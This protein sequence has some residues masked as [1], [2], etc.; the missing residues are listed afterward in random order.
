MI[1]K[2]LIRYVYELMGLEIVLSK[3]TDINSLPLYMIKKY[4]LFNAR[5]FDEDFIVMFVKND[6]EITL[7][8]IK[9]HIKQLYKVIPI[10]KRVVLVCSKISNYG[11]HSLIKEK[12]PFIV[13]GLQLYVPFLG[14]AYKERIEEKY[15]YM[16][17]E[18]EK[19]ETD[20][21]PKRLSPTTQAL[22]FELITSGTFNR[23]QLDLAETIGIS[24]I[25]VS[26]G[27][28]M[29]ELLGIIIKEK[30]GK[31]NIHIFKDTGRGI[32]ENIESYMVNPVER[33]VTVSLE[34][35]KQMNSELIHSSGESA[36]SEV[37]MLSEPRIKTYAMYKSDWNHLLN[38]PEELPSF[39]EDTVKIEL[40]SH[41]VPLLKGRIHPIALYL[42]L[43]DYEDERISS[44]ADNLIHNYDWES[45]VS[46]KEGIKTLYK[47]EEEND[48]QWVSE[49]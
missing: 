29:L 22:F 36:L 10:N 15:I 35:L 48:G 8:S 20:S 13:I 43:K 16:V 24:K 17:N 39:V 44:L 32:W 6:D 42:S 49:V 34:S 9:Q 2:A 4:E 21:L 47:L 28:Q 30:K 46:T 1:E 37:S 25:A 7:R 45:I 18:S 38:P 27:F 23:T 14:V 5:L 33:I 26:R 40:W 41:P 3:W 12:I 19:D 31:K 11:R